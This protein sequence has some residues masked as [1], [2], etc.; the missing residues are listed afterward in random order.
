MVIQM[1]VQWLRNRKI[2]LL[3]RRIKKNEEYL[4][5]FKDYVIVT[6]IWI[7]EDK[8]RLKQILKVKNNERK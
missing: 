2:K 4:Q 6:K 1:L 8:K 3:E 5:K 7:R